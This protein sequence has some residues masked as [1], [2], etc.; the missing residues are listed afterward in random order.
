[1]RKK[2]ATGL[3]SGRKA[4]AALAAQAVEKAMKKSGIK[5]PSA[6]LL[7]LSAEFAADPESAI[8]AAAKA[9][10]CTQVIGCSATGIFTEEDWILDSPA[11]AAMV[12]SDTA[13]LNVVKDKTPNNALLMTLAAPNAMNS[14]WLNKPGLRFGGISGDAVGQGPFSVWENGK[15]STQGY[16]EVEIEHAKAAVAASHGLKSFSKPHNITKTHGHNLLTIND[17]DAVKHLNKAWQ[18]S[19]TQVQELPLHKIVAIYA[20]HKEALSQGEYHVASIIVN[21]ESSGTVTLSKALEEG[22]WMRWA[23]RDV[24]AAQI[25]IVKTATKLGQQ[26]E[27]DPTFA[28]LFSCLG[29]GPSFYVGSDQD[30]ELLKTLFPSLPIIGFYGNGEIAPIAGQNEMLQYSAVLGLFSE[31]AN[32]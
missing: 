19:D 31:N 24:N 6:V 4:D 26:L 7:F 14:T 20:N 25:D 1:M 29:R 32:K 21:D 16:C 27:D 18:A 3:A 5:A 12:F 10:S 22:C 13:T 28:L 8:K 2:V 15:G 9:A 23:V 11:A 30:L 17:I